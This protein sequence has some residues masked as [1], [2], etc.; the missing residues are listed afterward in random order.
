MCG[1]FI[2]NHCG[3]LHRTMRRKPHKRR[4]NTLYARSTEA[5]TFGVTWDTKLP[6]LALRVQGNSRSY[7]LIYRFG[8]RPRWLKLGNALQITDRDARKLAR[9]K[10]VQVANGI[11]PGAERRAERGAGTF[12]DLA[13]SY[14]ET[15][16]K[17]RNKSWQQAD[18]LVR[19][20]L[21]L[22]AKLPVKNITRAEVRSAISKIDAPIAANQALAAASAIFSWAVQQELIPFNPARGVQRN[23]TQS[24]ERVL[25]DDELPVVWPALSTPL[26]LT[27]LTGQRPGEVTHMRWQDLESGWWT[28]PGRPV[29]GWPG[30]KN[31]QS[32]RVC[33]PQP[34]QAI[35]HE[36]NHGELSGFVFDTGNGPPRELHGSMRTICKM[37][38]LERTTPHDLRRTH[39]TMITRLG[40]GRDAMNRIQNHREGG[41]A[42]VYDQH[43]YAEENQRIME[44][45]AAHLLA[46][47]EGKA[48]ASNVVP[49]T[50]GV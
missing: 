17:R 41:I 11:D 25:T 38:K 46:L 31:G 50:K 13:T 19:R 24:R 33:L 5:A 23:P 40:F 32:H 26:K 43:K 8:K 27:L 7:V 45:V 37:L 1:P 22:W 39:G 21:W 28:M 36:L 2:Y 10:Q 12:G 42:D 4:L 44:A 15:Y 48:E 34:V 16:A 3:R 29:N 20:Y 18:A 35:L 49:L 30:T 47:A 14:V 6:G 9:E